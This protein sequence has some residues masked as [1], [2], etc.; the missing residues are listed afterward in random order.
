M[1]THATLV[2]VVG[3]DDESIGTPTNVSKIHKLQYCFA[4]INR[5]PRNAP[6][7]SSTART[8]SSQR[9][10]A[11]AVNVVDCSGGGKSVAQKAPTPTCLGA[12]LFPRE[13]SRRSVKGMDDPV[14]D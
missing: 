5:F 6:H 11:D 2:V 3:D 10:G 1:K 7:D 12:A 4:W 14:G 9:K 8:L 13:P